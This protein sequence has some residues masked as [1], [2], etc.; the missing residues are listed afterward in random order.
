MFNHLDE[1][2]KTGSPTNQNIY[3]NEDA[4][5][6]CD[7]HHDVTFHDD[8]ENDECYKHHYRCE[9]CKKITQIG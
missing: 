5:C 4:W 8:G 1:R 6:Q 7:D 2:N 9:A 3:E